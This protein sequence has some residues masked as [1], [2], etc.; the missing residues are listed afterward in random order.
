MNLAVLES[1]PQCGRGP[2]VVHSGWRVLPHGMARKCRPSPDTVLRAV[3][4][5]P[6]VFGDDAPVKLHAVAGGSETT[7]FAEMA[8]LAHVPVASVRAR[9]AEMVSIGQLD[10]VEDGY[11]VGGELR[12]AVVQI[13]GGDR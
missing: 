6:P 4:D 3:L 8:A 9:F 2:Y 11:L 1:C 13:A 12:D 7:T 5:M 10:P